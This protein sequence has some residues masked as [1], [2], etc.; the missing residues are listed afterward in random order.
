MSGT[1]GYDDDENRISHTT[2]DDPGS[3]SWLLWLS[4]FATLVSLVLLPFSA[5]S[6]QIAGYLLASLGAFT[7]V[8]LFRRASV[9]RFLLVSIGT[10]RSANAAATALLGVGLVVSIAHA[11]AIARHFA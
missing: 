8:A 10:T 9:A 6:L 4:L 7:L 11:Y 3:P 5:L 1:F 2:P